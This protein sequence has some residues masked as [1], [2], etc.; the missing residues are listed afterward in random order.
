[1]RR[2][3]DNDLMAS[4][5]GIGW[6]T[7]D[8]PVWHARTGALLTRAPSTCRIPATI[9][10]P[11][12]F[13]T[14]LFENANV[15]DSIHRNEALGEPLLLLSYGVFVAIRDAASAP[16]GHQRD[17]QLSAPATGDSTLRAVS[18]VRSVAG[19]VA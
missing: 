12:V 10:L 3:S 19:V 16:G 8:E 9:D 15:E 13:N 18:S 6:M 2:D 14:R 1:M 7:G 17:A 11:T 5:R 4:I